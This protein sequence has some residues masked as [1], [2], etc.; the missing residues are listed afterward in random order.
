MDRFEKKKERDIWK[1]DTNKI[2]LRK[3]LNEVNVC[4]SIVYGH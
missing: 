3:L 1:S 2:R 4:N